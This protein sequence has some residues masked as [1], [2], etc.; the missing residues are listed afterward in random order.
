MTFLST[1]DSL[2]MYMDFKKSIFCRSTLDAVLLTVAAFI[3]LMLMPSVSFAQALPWEGGICRFAKAAVGPWLGYVAVLAIV[4]A[5]IAFG[6]G[7]SNGP[8]KQAM[9]IVGGISIAVGALTVVQWFWPNLIA[10][11]VC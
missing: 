11:Q 6:V 2:E 1:T 3:V 8:F 4:F 9:Q 10:S 7:E 5:A